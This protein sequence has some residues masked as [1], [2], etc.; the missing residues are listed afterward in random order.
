MKIRAPFKIG[1][2]GI[3]DA[4]FWVFT[5]GIRRVTSTFTV[6]QVQDETVIEENK[7][8]KPMFVWGWT[9]RNP[10]N[11]NLNFHPWRKA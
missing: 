10:A 1:Q 11:G 7:L 8:D 2:N 3:K 5:H 4:G 9:V 6:A